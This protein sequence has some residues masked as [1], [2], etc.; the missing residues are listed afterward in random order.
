MLLPRHMQMSSNLP[1]FLFQYKYPRIAASRMITVMTIPA[2]P[3]PVSPLSPASERHNLCQQS[4]QKLTSL[5]P[6]WSPLTARCPALYSKSL[7]VKVHFLGL[8]RS[9]EKD[10][11][12]LCSE[13][14]SSRGSFTCGVRLCDNCILYVIEIDRRRL[15]PRTNGHSFD[16]CSSQSWI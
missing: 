7:W 5:I 11:L 8:L 9:P 15:G 3:P 12:P 4:T 1:I 10:I 13:S 2:I 16:K 14:E 6:A